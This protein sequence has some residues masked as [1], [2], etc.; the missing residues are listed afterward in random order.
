[1]PRSLIG[2]VYHEPLNRASR[3]VSII[4]C[5]SWSMDVE[6]VFKNI[7]CIEEVKKDCEPWSAPPLGMTVG[8]VKIVEYDHLRSAETSKP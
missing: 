8:R 1:M 5:S 3:Y 2:V 4:L 7:A 6:M